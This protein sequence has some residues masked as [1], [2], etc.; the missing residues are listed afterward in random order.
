[1]ASRYG[2]IGFRLERLLDPSSQHISFN[3]I[4]CWFPIRTITSRIADEIPQAASPSRKQRGL[5][6]RTAR[7]SDIEKRVS[8][9]RDSFHTPVRS[10]EN[11]HE[12]FHSLQPTRAVQVF[13]LHTRHRSA[14]PLAHGGCCVGWSPTASLAER[15]VP[16]A[17]GS[18]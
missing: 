17:R 3:I 16:S 18:A 11:D 10:A 9:S 14:G 13:F 5:V 1:M 2:H 12:H 8:G 7:F 15:N 6:T 4:L